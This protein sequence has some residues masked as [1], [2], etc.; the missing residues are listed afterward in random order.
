VPDQTP[1]QRL[2]SELHDFR[3]C[4]GSPRK[5]ARL[6]EELADERARVA[7]TPTVINDHLRE[8]IQ[9][10]IDRLLVE[11]ESPEVIAEE[12]A[13][14]PTRLGTEFPDEIDR[15]ETVLGSEL[16][17]GDVVRTEHGERTVDVLISGAVVLVAPFGGQTTVMPDRA[18]RRRV[19]TVEGAAKPES[20]IWTDPERMGGT[21]C[22]KGTRFPVDQ[23]LREIHTLGIRGFADEYGVTESLVISAVLEL[24]NIGLAARPVPEASPPDGWESVLGLYLQEG[25]ELPGGRTVQRDDAGWLASFSDD[26][27]DLHGPFIDPT[28]K[29]HRLVR[30]A[31]VEAEKTTLESVKGSALREGDQV[32]ALAS[33]GYVIASV[34][35]HKDGSL[36][37]M[38]EGYHPVSLNEDYRRVVRAAPVEAEPVCR[39]CGKALLPEN[40]RTVADGCPCNSRRGINH[41][42]VPKNTCTCVE[43]DPEQTGSTRYPPTPMRPTPVR[44]DSLKVGEKCWIEAKVVNLPPHA[45]SRLVALDFDVEG[46][47]YASFPR[48]TLVLPSEPSP[49]VA[50]EA[51][52]L[53]DFED[54]SYSSNDDLGPVL[55]RHVG[56]TPVAAPDWLTDEMVELLRSAGFGVAVYPLRPELTD[57]SMVKY[58]QLARALS[59]RLAPHLDDERKAWLAEVGR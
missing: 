15:F 40:T 30:P 23:A 39:A 34:E 14:P 54:G 53:K 28:R 5:L 55:V 44:V 11:R 6:I 48:D 12:A 56:P 51:P 19:C 9:R 59:K 7:S 33:A 50:S 26:D 57:V 32:R 2:A 1:T 43:C 17:E 49:T 3:D 31:P 27:E 4:Y 41:G 24:A 20:V 38:N 8:H 21:P 42:L 16:R 45:S 35:A 13:R 46:H 18:Y 25:D 22:L 58:E 10:E 36:Y 29:Y 47:Y 52:R 37:V